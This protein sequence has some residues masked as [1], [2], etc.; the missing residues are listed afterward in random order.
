MV[1]HRLYARRFALRRAGHRCLWCGRA[2]TQGP[3]VTVIEPLGETVWTA[4]GENHASRQKR[5]FAV[6]HSWRWILRGGI[7]G[8]LVLFL[9]LAF[10]AATLHAPPFSFADARAFFRLTVALTV[11]PFAC[12]VAVSTAHEESLARSPFP[13]HIQ[14]LIGTRA[15]LWLLRLVGL[16]WGGLGIHYFLWQG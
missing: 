5:V 2:V 11:V 10:S 16:V 9:G 12:R 15:V 6:A 8:A 3:A 7:L 14:A 4:C 1:T 13:V